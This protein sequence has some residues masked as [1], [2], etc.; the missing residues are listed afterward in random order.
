MNRKISTLLTAG[1][2]VAGSLCGS[3]FAQNSIQS[4]LGL[5]SAVTELKSGAYVMTDANGLA[6]GFTSVS[7]D[8]VLREGTLDYNATSITDDEKDNVKQYIWKVTVTENLGA[9]SYKFENVATGKTLRVNTTAKAV[10]LNSMASENVIKDVFAFGTTQI[11]LTG[12]YTANEKALFAYN[13]NKNDVFQLTWSA[14]SSS[15]STTASSFDLSFYAVES[16]EL[17]L[18]G[19][20]E[21]NDLYNTAGF[22]FVSKRLD[23]DQTSEPKGNLFNEK[24]IVARYVPTALNVDATSYPSYSGSAA[25]LKIPEGMYFFT[26]NA[27]DDDDCSGTNAVSNGYK[28][29][30]D[31]TVLVLSSTETV[32]GTNA[33]RA[34]GDGFMLV[35]KKISE[36]NLYQGTSS[37]WKAVAMRSP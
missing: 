8:G 7:E 25:D 37:N 30:M 19:A 16:E 35:E 34:S 21:L 2:L 17:G 24:R 28:A 23:S 3:A 12:K 33:G 9:Y 32:E 1:L 5:G 22:S 4:L 13:G 29:W 14:G 11:G 18:V 36:L 15:I 31:A 20:K 6:Y 10:E 26:E 27:P